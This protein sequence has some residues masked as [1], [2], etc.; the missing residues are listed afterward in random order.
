MAKISL[1]NLTIDKL[2]ALRADIDAEL[3]QRKKDSRKKVMAEVQKLLAQNDM[4][5]D[6]LPARP[7]RKRGSGGTRGKV[8]AKYANPKNAAETWTGRGRKPLWVE[9]HLKAGGK[10]ADLLIK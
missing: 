5:L 3:L 6:D 4:S 10:V 8:P 9:A 7:G 2:K 1:T